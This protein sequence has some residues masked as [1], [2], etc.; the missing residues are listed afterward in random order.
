MKIDRT[1]PLAP[2][3]SLSEDGWT[4]EAVEVAIAAGEPGP[5]GVSETEY[6]VG[7]TGEWV[8][9]KT[10][11]K[12]EEAGEHDIYARTVDKAGNVGAESQS[13]VKID[14]TKPLAPKISLSEDGW[15]NEA[16]EV[17]IAAGEPNFIQ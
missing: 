7:A 2:K 5:S 8:T 3:I 16:V 15:T 12:I 13:T 4:N 6:K 17:A 14:R 1:K 9:Y 10:P 11:F